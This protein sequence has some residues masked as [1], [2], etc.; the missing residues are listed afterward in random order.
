M[1]LIKGL[2]LDMGRVVISPIPATFSLIAENSKGKTGAALILPSIVTL[3]LG[4]SYALVFHLP[5]P[6]YSLLIV[7][8]IL[9][10]LFI[11]FLS[12]LLNLVYKS[13]LKRKRNFQEE[14]LY[15]ISLLLT[16]FLIIVFIQPPSTIYWYSCTICLALLFLY[17]VL[18]IRAITKV[19]WWQA[20]VIVLFSVVTSA[21]G[22]Y[23]FGLFLMSMMWTMP[24]VF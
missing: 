4:I 11:L 10:P 12:Y 16:A 24:R 19:H 14:F 3:L 7:G 5:V 13:L 6:V 21:M 18:G 8:V 17:L 9:I 15:L 1:D 23:C 22:T 2:F 20:S